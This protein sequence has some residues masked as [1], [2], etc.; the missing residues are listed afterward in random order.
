MCAWVHASCALPLLRLHTH[1]Q[2]WPQARAPSRRTVWCAHVRGE[3]AALSWLLARAWAHPAC[4]VPTPLQVDDV[5]PFYADLM[6][7][8]YD[9]VCARSG[10]ACC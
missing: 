4:A 8:L 7:V 3:H 9:K 10:K 2:A 5:H 1:G 6:N